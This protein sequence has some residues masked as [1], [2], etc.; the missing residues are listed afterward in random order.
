MDSKKQ[1]QKG[2]IIR[3]EEREKTKEQKRFKA[4]T[5]T[6]IELLA[7]REMLFKPL[8]PNSKSKD[9]LLKTPKQIENTLKKGV[10][11]KSKELGGRGSL[12][13][14][15]KNF[16]KQLAAVVVKRDQCIFGE[17][18]HRFR[19]QL[20]P[21]G[22]FADRLNKITKSNTRELKK[23]QKILSGLSGGSQQMQR[24]LSELNEASQREINKDVKII[25]KE[26][27]KTEKRLAR[28]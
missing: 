5:E 6:I 24:I 20:T 1:T 27:R 22:G 16:L 4:L 9:S 25:S 2:E 15:E 14:E 11:K 28:F 12:S 26:V 19:N 7:S 18:C 23:V 10:I 21:I 8:K 13:A 3:R 17:Y